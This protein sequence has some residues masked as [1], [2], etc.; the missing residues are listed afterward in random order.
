MAVRSCVTP[1]ESVG[2]SDIVTIEAWG[3]LPWAHLQQ[4]CLDQ[5]VVQWGCRSSGQNMSAVA[6]IGANPSLTD[7]DIDAV[8]AGNI[9]RR[10]TYPRIGAAIKQAVAATP[11]TG[12]GGWDE[13]GQTRYAI[14]SKQVEFVRHEAPNA[15]AER[16]LRACADPGRRD[17][18]PRAAARRRGARRGPPARRTSQ[19]GRRARR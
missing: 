3:R 8:M 14:P 9:G 7:E 2:G 19:T 12:N 16:P 17:E 13:T 1:V 5:E 4:A 11:A 15:S 10:G 6:L 18:Y